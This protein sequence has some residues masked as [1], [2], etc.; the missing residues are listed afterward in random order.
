MTRRLFFWACV[1]AGTGWVA[2]GLIHVF[3]DIPEGGPRLAIG[4]LFWIIAMLIG[5]RR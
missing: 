3:G 1:I 4:S 2:L 5:D